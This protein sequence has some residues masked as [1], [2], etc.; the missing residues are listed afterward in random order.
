MNA[1][2]AA[3]RVVHEVLYK[4]GYSNIALEQ[5]LENENFN[6]QDAG[7]TTEI[8]LGTLR[9]KILLENI[10]AE[11]SNIKVNKISPSAMSALLTGTYQ[12]LFMDRTPD[13][14]ACNES[15]KIA[16]KFAGQKVRG[17]VNA[18][19][20][21]ISREKNKS[22]SVLNKKSG[23]EGIS[24]RYSCSPAA[25]KKLI[26][27][28]GEQKTIE[29]LSHMNQPA[30]T[31]IRFNNFADNK[32]NEKTLVEQGIG[33]TKGIISSSSYY[34]ELKNPVSALSLFKNGIISIQDEG[35]QAMGEFLSPKPG[36]K[37]LDACASPGGKTIHL[38]CLMKNT[39]EITA[40]DIHSQRVENMK[41]NFER[42][43]CSIIKSIKLDMSLKHTEFIDEFDSVLLD[44]PCSGLG[45]AQRRPEIKLFYRED[46]SLYDVQWKILESCADYVKPG[47]ELVY[48]TCTLFKEENQEMVERLISHRDDFSVTEE[49]TILPDGTAGGFYMAKLVRKI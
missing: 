41:S 36:S 17:F 39:G 12:I 47:G 44:V 40:C 11:H 32:I 24:V 35:A 46:P 16:S 8:V 14:A 21:S 19:L 38:A 43:G 13:S 48:G 18:V 29:L 49:K 4:E 20:R 27:Q 15:V 3:F 6:S 9:N 34:P 42:T 5:I 22:E 7:F 31:C 37:V 1:R 30:K 23:E 33:Y 45:T 2:E 25:V 10:I 28:Y 26:N